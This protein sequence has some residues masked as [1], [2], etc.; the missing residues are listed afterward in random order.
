MAYTKL[1]NSIITSTIWMED[2]RTRIVWITMLACADKN[3]EVQ[4]SIPGLARIAGVPIEDCRAA[5]TRFLSHDLDS[6]T[7]DDE[8]R[9]VE[10]IRGGWSLLNFRKYREMAS[11]EESQANAAERKARYREG[12]SRNAKLECPAIVPNVP[13]VSTV[14]QH[15]AEAEAEADTEAYTKAKASTKAAAGRS[16]AP[17]QGVGASEVGSLPRDHVK[18]AECGPRFLICLSPTQ[19]A[20][21]APRYNGGTDAANRAG[22]AAFLGYAEALVGPN[23]SPGDFVWLLQHYD[24]WLASQGRIP[25][26][27]AKTSGKPQPRTAAQ[28]I[29]SMRAEGSL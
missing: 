12:L 22:V 21:F 26:A 9:R 11:K 13:L 5:I 28:I 25:A 6:R 8:G 15:I 29:E 20:K 19:Y 17:V 10:E 27:P 24:A 3:G 14:Y 7:K 2:D 18:H 16:S 1:F 23:Q 4:A